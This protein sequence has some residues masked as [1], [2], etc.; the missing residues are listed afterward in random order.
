MSLTIQYISNSFKC[1]RTTLLIEESLATFL[2][3]RG[4]K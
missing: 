3:K 1:Q 2:D 4:G